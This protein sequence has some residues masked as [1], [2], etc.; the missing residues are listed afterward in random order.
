MPWRRSRRRRHHL[1]STRLGTPDRQIRR[2][3]AAGGEPPAQDCCAGPQIEDEFSTKVI[4][5]L[6]EVAAETGKLVP[7]IALNWLFHRPTYRQ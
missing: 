6:D 4:D 7:Q 1:E 3:T 5:A 2:A